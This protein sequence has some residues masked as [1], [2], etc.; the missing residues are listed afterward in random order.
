MLNMLAACGLTFAGGV[1]SHVV[2][3][4]R[5]EH[6]LHGA[7]YLLT[8]VALYTGWIYAAVAYS[9]DTLQ[10]AAV[11]VSAV[12]AC[13]LAGLFASLVLYRTLLSPLCRFPGPVLARVSDFGFS[14]QLGRLDLFRVLQRFHAAHGDFVRVGSNTLSIR[15]PGAVEAVHG[16]RSACRKADFYDLTR[17]MTSMHTARD[18]GAHD[19]R[20]REWSPA[21]GDK[22]LRGY[23][24][25]MRAYQDRLVAK[26]REAG[27]QPVE[28]MKWFALFSF[29]VLGDLAFGASFGMLE[30]RELHWAVRL[31][32][33][34]LRPHGLMMPTWFLRMMMMFPGLTR[35]YWRFV[36]F[37]RAQLEERIRTTPEVPDIMSALLQPYAKAGPTADD[38]QMLYGESQLIVVAGRSV[39]PSPGFRKRR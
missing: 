1:A 34:G 35:D 21:F 13:Y 39:A 26:L 28:V 9:G 29:D 6:H 31:L 25:R 3:F 7:R 16:A 36:G 11:R 22:A 8:F 5:G 10:C 2:Y 24:E 30:A 14:T 23:E 19:R 38:M 20:R 32:R 18:R 17:P 15:H 4:N 33:A 12:A 27:G 37:C